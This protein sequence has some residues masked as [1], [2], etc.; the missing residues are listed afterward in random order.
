MYVLIGSEVGDYA[1]YYERYRQVLLCSESKEL[2]EKYWDSLPT[3]ESEHG[4][5]KVTPLGGEYI[6][7]SI[8]LIEELAPADK[9]VAKAVEL[10]EIITFFSRYFKVISRYPHKL[11]LEEVNFGKL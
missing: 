7:Y 3:K 1:D 5:L 6:D 9:P 10:G 11:V 8:E 4:E 2:L